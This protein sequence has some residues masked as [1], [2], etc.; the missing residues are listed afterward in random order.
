MSPLIN[1]NK[2]KRVIE[3]LPNRSFST[4]SQFPRNANPINIG[5]EP[6]TALNATVPEAATVLWIILM[7]LNS[8]FNL[9]K[10]YL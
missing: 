2:W 6:I 3:K 1:E 7:Y 10:E 8:E 4:N 9:S 5:R